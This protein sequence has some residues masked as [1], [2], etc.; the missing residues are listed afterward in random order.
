MHGILGSDF[1]SKHLAKIDYEHSTLV[2]HDREK[3]ICIPM[4]SKANSMFTI[5]ARCE[6][7]KYIPVKEKSDSVIAKGEICNGVFV[8][9]TIVRPTNNCVPIRFL[10]TRDENIQI[11]NFQ[12]VLEPLANYNICKLSENATNSTERTRKLLSVLKT[13]HLNKEESQSL[14]R[15]CA[16]YCDVFQLDGDR[17]PVTNCYKQKIHLKEAAKAVYVKPYRLPHAKN[18]PM[19]MR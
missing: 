15:V 10:N 12:P 1:L 17:L 4:Q 6:I 7:I 8:G 16:K 13:D 11:K 3:E 14:E 5:P 18:Q 9:S 2:L 19:A